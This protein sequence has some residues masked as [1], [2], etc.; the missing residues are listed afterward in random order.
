MD[1]KLLIMDVDGTLTDGKIH[2][3]ENGELFKSFYARDGYAIKEI[4]PKYNIFPIILTGRNSKITNIRAKELNI[5]YVYQGIDEKDIVIK[6]ICEKHGVLASQ[7]A[8][9]GDDLNDLEAMKLVG[10]V[11]CPQNAVS[12]VREI[13][14]FISK[15][16]G[17]DGAVREFVEFIVKSI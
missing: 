2:I 8:Y 13:A 1:I 3:G 12:G 17:G 15:N 11:G 9:I 14:D 16:V 6:E 5:D 4:L 10:L 7:I